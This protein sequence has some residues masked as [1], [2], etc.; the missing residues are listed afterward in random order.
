MGVPDQLFAALAQSQ[1]GAQM[2][3]DKGV[4]TFDYDGQAFAVLTQKGQGLLKLEAPQ[5]AALVSLCPKG[6]SADQIDGWTSVTFKAMEAALLADYVGAA[7][8]TVAP[9]ARLVF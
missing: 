1:K 9:K 3:S 4:L 5:H 7:Y 6:V 2:T 8:R